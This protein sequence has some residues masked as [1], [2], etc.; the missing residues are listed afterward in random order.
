MQ[1][2]ANI[3]SMLKFLAKYEETW[4]VIFKMWY[5]IQISANSFEQL[6]SPNSHIVRRDAV[7]WLTSPHA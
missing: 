5:Y 6:P 1:C 4:T 2:K 3:H 7:T